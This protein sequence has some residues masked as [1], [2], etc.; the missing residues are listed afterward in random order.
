LPPS[1]QP[2]TYPKVTTGWIEGGNFARTARN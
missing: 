2:V 1:I